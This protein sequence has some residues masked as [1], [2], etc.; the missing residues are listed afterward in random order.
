VFSPVGAPLPVL[1]M[2]GTHAPFRPLIC[3]VLPM[4]NL[5]SS[6]KPAPSPTK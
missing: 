5:D 6:A 2:L 4:L 1:A 3:S